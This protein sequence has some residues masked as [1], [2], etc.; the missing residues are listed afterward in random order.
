MLQLNPNEVIRISKLM[1]YSLET[2]KNDIKYLKNK[3]QNTKI[4]QELDID[5]LEKSTEKLTNGTIFL[6]NIINE[7][8]EAT[9]ESL[10]KLLSSNHT[11]NYF[12]NKLLAHYA[13]K[14]NNNESKSKLET[15]DLCYSKD[16]KVTNYCQKQNFIDYANTYFNN[17][18]AEKYGL[19][20]DS[21]IN[22]LIYVYDKRGATEAYAVMN[23]LEN[24]SPNNYQ[25]YNFNP[26][27]Q[28]NANSYYDYNS[29]TINN[30]QTNSEIID[31]NGYK[32]EIA[33][34]L[35]KDC[36]NAE[37]LAYN[38]G[39]ANIINTMKT[40]PDKFLSICSQGNSNVITLTCNRNAMNNNAN[41][42]GYYKPS[43]LFS[44]KTNMVTIDI[45]GSFNDNTFYTQDTLIHE[46]GHKFDD[47]SYDKN[48]ID[49]ILGRITYTDTSNEWKNAYKEY[50][51]I[52]SAIN[53]GGYTSYPNVNEFFGD[54]MVAYM[55]NPNDV[56]SMCPSV[57][58]LISN[59]LGGEYGYS[60]D[61]R[62][63][64]VLNT[65]D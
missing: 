64:Y 9:G 12:E 43:A 55:K 49:Q 54:A 19:D 14:I 38:F 5:S 8:V 40:L 59:M 44:S 11:L 4:I 48:I 15:I 62:I 57:Y 56:K 65:V 10:D 24:N 17:F 2:I 50:N 25:D 21:I 23:A 47:I 31:I 16:D 33:Q 7:L 42:S 27:S 35:P 39:K 20:K 29:K 46:L 1:N 37:M 53:L 6:D 32:Y 36:T 22:D 34:V 28:I 41:W 18:D 30:Y 3:Y 45:R 13:D 63:A 52:L 26:T 60:Y 51:S 58:N 61:E